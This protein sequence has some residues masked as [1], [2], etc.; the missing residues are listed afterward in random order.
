MVTDA[1]LPR[2]IP[3][4]TCCF[5]QDERCVAHT[6][7]CLPFELRLPASGVL[8]PGNAAGSAGCCPCSTLLTEVVVALLQGN[9]AGIEPLREA[10]ASLSA[11]LRKH[12]HG[13][14]GRQV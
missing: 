2:A 1:S 5:H 9:L 11:Q 14:T 8:S 12:T 4:Y 6:A 10:Q 13:H 7:A 3:A